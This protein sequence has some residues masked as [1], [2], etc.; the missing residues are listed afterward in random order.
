MEQKR[1]VQRNNYS[2]LLLIVIP[3][4]FLTCKFR[5]VKNELLVKHIYG[6]NKSF[7]G[8]SIF[9]GDLL[10]KV[11]FI[12]SS[13]G[14][15][16]I[17]YARYPDNTLK[18]ISTFKNGL[19]VF[20]RIEFYNNGNIKKYEFIDIESKYSYERDYNEN[21]VLDSALGKPFFSCILAG[22]NGRT[23]QHDSLLSAYLYAPI[24]PN[25]ETRI[26]TKFDDSTEEDFDRRPYLKN[27]FRESLRATKVGNQEWDIHMKFYDKDMDTTYDISTPL[28]FKVVEPNF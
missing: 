16:S 24:P 23:V 1:I 15:D 25:V 28:I 11:V 5:H 27:L 8:D 14:I 2:Y 20:E 4:F 9:K 13:F 17:T 18:S 21:G 6:L 26:Y 12:D 22:I 7:L 3:I 10:L 19:P